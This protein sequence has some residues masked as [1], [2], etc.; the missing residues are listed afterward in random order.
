MAT[1]KVVG[2]IQ[3][4]DSAQLEEV[5]C[6]VDQISVMPNQFCSRMVH[7]S[8]AVILSDPKVNKLKAIPQFVWLT[9]ACLIKSYLLQVDV[10]TVK[11]LQN[12]TLNKECALKLNVLDHDNFLI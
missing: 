2:H 12:Q 4:G 7:A 1:V 3:D 6:N 9:L 8:C 5:V 10:K 11:N